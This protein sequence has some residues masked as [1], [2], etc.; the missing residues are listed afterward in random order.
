MKKA[1]FITVILLTFSNSNAAQKKGNVK[2]VLVKYGAFEKSS[3]WNWHRSKRIKDTKAPK[4][5]LADKKAEKSAVNYV[6]KLKPNINS[7]STVSQRMRLKPATYTISFRARIDG[8]S[9][10]L[11][12]V[13]LSASRSKGDSRS[14][15]ISSLNDVNK[16]WNTFEETFTV[17]KKNKLKYLVF[18]NGNTQ[19]VALFID[20]V[21]INPI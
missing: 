21:V 1:L 10:S 15:H 5:S 14:V 9:S 7:W 19:G 11:L 16:E 3:K 12:S 6:A 2:S 8:N 17:D 13:S 4:L 18:H 20:D